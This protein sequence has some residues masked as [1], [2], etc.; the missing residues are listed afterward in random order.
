MVHLVATLAND[1]DY[2][3]SLLY[4]L[5]NEVVLPPAQSPGE[6][7]GV[8]YYAEERALIIRK[9]AELLTTRTVFELASHVQS[10]VVL[11]CVQNSG[12][13]R[14]QSPPHRFRS[15]LF[16]YSG[17]L[18]PLTQ[19]RSR[20]V[21]KLPDFVKSEPGDA[22]GGALAFGMFLA[23]LH[24]AGA[25]DDMLSPNDVFGQALSRTADA[26]KRLG[27][28]VGAEPIRAAYVATNGRLVIASRSGPSLYWKLQEGLEPSPN[29]PAEHALGEFKRV[30][31]ALK[32]F[33]AIVLAREVVQG[34]PGWTE[35]QDGTTVVIDRKLNLR[36]L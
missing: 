30:A 9:P 10:S 36:T 25:L 4:A 14:E 13:N 6:T 5:R 2:M 23:E 19:L 21:D 7:W 15:W 12:D 33:R 8:G 17:D 31:E 11:A 20:I 22:T 35:I 24:R 18:H 1:A 29:E 34:R 3:P 16:G 26:V 32:R 28:E 27:T